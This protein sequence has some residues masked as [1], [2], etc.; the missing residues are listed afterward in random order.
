MKFL[1]RCHA[2]DYVVQGEGR[3]FHQLISALQNGKDGLGEEIP[4]YGAAILQVNLW[5]PLRP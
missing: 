1:N 5:D 3:S 2:V 4:V